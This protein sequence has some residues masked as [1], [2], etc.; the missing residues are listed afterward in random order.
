MKIWRGLVSLDRDTF[1]VRVLENT[2]GS[3][4]VWSRA[5]VGQYGAF[6]ENGF[7]VDSSFIGANSAAVSDVDGTISIWIDPG[8]QPNGFQLN[9]TAGGAFTDQI[10]QMGQVPIEIL[11][12]G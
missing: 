5:G 6:L 11:V 3:D 7:P 9:T 12:Y 1:V 10:L 4:I 2:L 8:G